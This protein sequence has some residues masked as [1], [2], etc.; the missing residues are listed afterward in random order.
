M[1]GWVLRRPNGALLR[2]TLASTAVVAW[3]IADD[4]ISRE[5]SW[6]RKLSHAQFIVGAKQRGYRLLRVRMVEK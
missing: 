1:S 6:P 3:R 5:L 4:I 2:Q